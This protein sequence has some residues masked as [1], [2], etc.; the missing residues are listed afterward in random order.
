[1]PSLINSDQL[2]SAIPTIQEVQ[3]VGLQ[4][5]EELVSSDAKRRRLIK[6]GIYSACR[7][8]E[9]NHRLKEKVST[10]N[11]GD[12][13]PLE[14][15]SSC[16]S[17]LVT[18]K[19]CLPKVTGDLTPEQLERVERNRDAAMKRKALLQAQQLYYK[20][21]NSITSATTLI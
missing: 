3:P 1:M 2:L 5:T 12:F 14:K 13:S 18:P 11:F 10:M 21:N 9:L 20:H 16:S 6:P 15:L 19:K 7:D 8:P 4:E 17:N